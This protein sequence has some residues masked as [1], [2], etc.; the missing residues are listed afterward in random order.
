V[1]GGGIRQ[2]VRGDRVVARVVVGLVA[3]MKR[4]VFAGARL[5]AELAVNEAEHV[6]RGHVLG[7]DAKGLL[8]LLGRAP[9][10]QLP[11]VVGFS[12]SLHLRALEQ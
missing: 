10:I 9:Q 4:G 3:R 12:S 2:P 1:V 5:I 6:V 8:E 7:V 11:A